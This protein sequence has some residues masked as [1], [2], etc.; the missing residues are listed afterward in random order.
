MKTSVYTFYDSK[1]KSYLTPFF[2][3]SDGE[4]KRITFET[5]KD[6]RTSLSKYPEDFTL[7]YLGEVDLQK[8]ELIPASINS[9]LGLLDQIKAEFD[10]YDSRTKIEE[11]KSEVE[12]EIS[13]ET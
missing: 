12:N 7:F 9:S 11:K 10:K 5:M 4:A 6:V 13:D 8:G 3:R 2:A 1:V